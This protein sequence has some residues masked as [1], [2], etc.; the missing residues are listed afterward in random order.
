TTEGRLEANVQQIREVFTK[1]FE[2]T[3]GRLEA[4]IQQIQEVFTKQFEATKEGVTKQLEALFAKR[5]EDDG[6]FQQLQG[7]ISALAG[8]QAQLL[9]L[10]NPVGEK[11]VAATSGRATEPEMDAAVPTI[12]SADLVTATTGTITAA[13]A[14]AAVTS[15][16]PTTGNTT[17]NP[18]SSA[19]GE[20]P[21]EE[22]TDHVREVP[23][24][25]SGSSATE[26]TEVFL[27]TPL[28]I[29]MAELELSSTRRVFVPANCLAMV[30]DLSREI[31]DITIEAPTDP[32]EHKIWSAVKQL[33]IPSRVGKDV[34][35]RGPPEP[36]MITHH[37]RWLP[38][39]LLKSA[40][41][42]DETEE[43]G[44]SRK[45]K[46]VLIVRKR[47]KRSKNNPL[48]EPSSVKSSED[49]R[50]T[51]TNLAFS[52]RAATDLLGTEKYPQRTALE[53]GKEP[54]RGHAL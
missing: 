24:P 32:E 18:T 33:S 8:M 31:S 9:A 45:R 15:A 23:L 22:N 51:A 26:V 25:C 11:A 4:N 43:K 3:E 27:P 39:D 46:V 5:V 34:I 41:A 53:K 35:Y 12:T 28:F 1:Q 50:T 54:L 42:K 2:M 6:K 40:S 19:N 30:Q 16:D 10:I 44:K 20:C 29:E 21:T 13:S 49:A 14:A 47:F 7:A 37:P 36:V 38:L 52:Y 48:E 17:S